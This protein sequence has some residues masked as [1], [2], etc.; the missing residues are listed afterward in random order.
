MN[1]EACSVGLATFLRLRAAGFPGHVAVYGLLPSGRVAHQYRWGR[2]TTRKHGSDVCAPVIRASAGFRGG[3][4]RV[5]Y[6][7]P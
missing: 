2:M 3:P 5:L 7:G 1:G 4:G 6:P